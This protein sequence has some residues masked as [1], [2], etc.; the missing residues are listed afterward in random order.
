MAKKPKLKKPEG[1]LEQWSKPIKRMRGEPV[2]HD[3]PK[4]ETAKICLTPKAK[5]RLLE[6]AALNKLSVSEYLERWLTGWKNLKLP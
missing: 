1:Q 3:Q 5:S 4:S 2:F 6:L